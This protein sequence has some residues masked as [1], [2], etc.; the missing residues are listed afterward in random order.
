MTKPFDLKELECLGNFWRCF[1]PV[2]GGTVSCYR[3]QSMQ[4]G[5]LNETYRQYCTR[6]NARYSKTPDFHLNSERRLD[7]TDEQFLFTIETVAS[8][9]TGSFSDLQE[10][11]RRLDAPQ[12]WRRKES[13]IRADQA[14]CDK[15]LKEIYVALRAKGYSWYDLI[16]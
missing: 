2:R 16:S 14:H 5:T 10:V 9:V 1:A 15:A 3:E 7:E 4:L 8:E 13:E 12:S 6:I 11:F